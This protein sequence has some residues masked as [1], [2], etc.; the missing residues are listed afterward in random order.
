[1]HVVLVG[2]MSSGKT[3]VGRRLAGRLDRPFLDADDVLQERLGCTITE[4]FEEHGEPWFR[5]REAELL[6][7]LLAPVEPIVLASGGGV[8]LLERNR[9]RLRRDDV[10]VVWLQATPEFLASRAERKAHRPLLA[11]AGGATVDLFRE[12]DRVRAPLYAEVA[13]VTVDI[14][15]F[16]LTHGKPKAALAEFVAHELRELAARRAEVAP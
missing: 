15:P 1:M 2:M 6:D 3:T 13:D 14:R 7:E 5:E 9:A 16:H 4:V 12:L 10:A 8:V 11:A